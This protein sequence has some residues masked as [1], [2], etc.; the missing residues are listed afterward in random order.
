MEWTDNIEKQNISRVYSKFIGKIDI[1]IV[2]TIL[3]INLLYLSRVEAYNNHCLDSIDKREMDRQHRRRQQPQHR[4]QKST[5]KMDTPSM[6]R[7]ETTT[8]HR[9]SRMAL[10]QLA[11]QCWHQQ[12]RPI[13]AG[14]EWDHQLSSLPQQQQ[15]A[16]TSSSRRVLIIE[17]FHNNISKRK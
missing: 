5:T 10:A 11:Q 8:R 3:S 4:Q 16:T 13:G 14:A 2:E 9:T 7:M 1:K 15:S 6:A 12:H 17:L